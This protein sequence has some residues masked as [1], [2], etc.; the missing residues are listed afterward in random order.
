MVGSWRDIRTNATLEYIF[1][2]NDTYT[3]RVKYSL[4]DCTGYGNTEYGVYEV[5]GETLELFPYGEKSIKLTIIETNK[6]SIAVSDEK[7]YESK[8]NRY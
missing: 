7:G 8:L 5:N 3:H 4:I 2:D 6:N 1:N